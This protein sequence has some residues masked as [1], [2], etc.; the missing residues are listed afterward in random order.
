[1]LDEALRLDPES[2]VAHEQ[3]GKLL[4]LQNEYPDA[5]LVY[6]RA[7]KFTRQ[8][9]FLFLE[10]RTY[11]FSGEKT[12]AESLF[13]QVERLMREDLEVSGVG[14]RNEL[15]ALLLERGN[16]KDLREA[17]AMAELELQSRHNI[18]TLKLYESARQ[19][20]HQLK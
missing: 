12:K 4:E 6:Q 7:F 2:S 1:M 16:P 17:L 5:A 11:K 14:H 13:S 10:A 9:K 15:T 3:M 19:R 8:L 20:I 18:E